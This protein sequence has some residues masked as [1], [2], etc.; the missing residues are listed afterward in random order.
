MIVSKNHFTLPKLEILRL[1]NQ[2]QSCPLAITRSSFFHVCAWPWKYCFSLERARPILQELRLCQQ[3]PHQGLSNPKVGTTGTTSS[4]I[5][6]K[7]EEFAKQFL[8]KASVNKYLTEGAFEILAL[9][10]REG[11]WGSDTCRDF[12][13]D[14]IVERHREGIMIIKYCRLLYCTNRNYFGI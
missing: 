12:W 10:K 5:L 11:G 13:V 9:P 3:P 2:A 8:K 4:S 7:A 6:I 14:W 1:D